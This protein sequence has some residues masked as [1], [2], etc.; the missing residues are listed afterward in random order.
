MD[1]LKHRIYLLEEQQLIMQRSLQAM[2]AIQGKLNCVNVLPSGAH[3][4]ESGAKAE[5]K[6]VE[7][8]NV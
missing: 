4:I 6:T 2:N 7:N 3:F 8:N 5:Q 1:D